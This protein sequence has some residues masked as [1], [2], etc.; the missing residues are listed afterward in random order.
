ML[1]PATARGPG[2]KQQPKKNHG[3]FCECLGI[4]KMGNISCQIASRYLKYH[5]HSG[6]QTWL[7]GESMS[8]R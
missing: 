1:S 2:K 6:N 5:L 8:D 7:A 4:M 3:D